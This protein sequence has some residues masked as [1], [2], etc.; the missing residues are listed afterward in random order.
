M[1]PIQLELP[2]IFEGMTVNAW[3]IKGETPTLVDCGEKT[4][5]C[6]DALLNGLKKHG[7]GIG[8]I[9]KVVIT[10]AHL[11]HIG[12]ANKITQHSD[13]TIWVN[14]YCYDWAI[15]LKTMLDRRTKAILGVAKRNLSKALVDKF[16]NFGYEMLS[17]YWDEIPAERLKVFPMKGTIKLGDEDW[18]IIYTPGHCINQTCFYNPRNGEFISA[19]MLLRIIASPIIDAGLKPPYQRVKSLVMHLASYQK[20]A[21]LNITKAFPGHFDPLEQVDLLVEKQI[22]KIHTRKEKCLE[23]IKSGMTQVEALTNYI[24]PKRMNNATL[25]MV[26][27]FIDILLDEGRIEAIEKDGMLHYYEKAMVQSR[28]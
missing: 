26:L 10:H 5:K 20:I 4:D 18:D 11:D 17:P 16:F 1:T 19:D 15:D 6:W 9:K 27:G 23:G 22:Q 14:E 7:L 2:T 8:D 25:F 3:L 28:K 24:Y 21:Q 12:M 13:A